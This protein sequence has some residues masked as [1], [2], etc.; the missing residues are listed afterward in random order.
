MEENFNSG[1]EL[2]TLT[3]LALPAEA[4]AI[5]GRAL[6]LSQPADRCRK[7]K[8]RRSGRAFRVRREPQS[9]HFLQPHASRVNKFLVGAE[10]QPDPFFCRIDPPLHRHV[11]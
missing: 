5:S 11:L 2:P 6:A 10:L 7:E 8:A 1:R 4:N 9:E 3:V